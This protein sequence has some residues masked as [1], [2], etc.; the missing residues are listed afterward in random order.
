MLQIKSNVL[1]TADAAANL[2]R[3][4]QTLCSFHDDVLIDFLSF[5]RPVEINHMHIPGPLLFK[6]FCDIPNTV[7]NTFL[8]FIISLIQPHGLLIQ[9]INCR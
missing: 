2:N 3:N 5:L 4:L 7:T 9:Y 6:C 1:H 8:L